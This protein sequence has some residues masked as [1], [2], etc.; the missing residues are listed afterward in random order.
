[1]KLSTITRPRPL[2]GSYATIFSRYLCLILVS[3]II[4]FTCLPLRAFMEHYRLGYNVDAQ[5]DPS[6]VFN[7]GRSVFGEDS[8]ALQYEMYRGYRMT[9][10]NGF[11][12]LSTTCMTEGSWYPKRTANPNHDPHSR[13]ASGS[14]PCQM[15]A[16]ALRDRK[17]MISSTNSC[18]CSPL[19]AV[20]RRPMRRSK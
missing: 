2:P 7:V 20:F 17:F 14:Y 16:L 1:M 19:H 5:F 11:I 12:H 8:I 3:T 13:Q 10:S 18:F 9:T 4:G 6:R 15:E